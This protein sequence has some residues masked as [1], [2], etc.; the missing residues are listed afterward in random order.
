MK[1]EGLA[2]EDGLMMR[3]MLDFPSGLELHIGVRDSAWCARPARWLVGSSTRPLGLPTRWSRWLV[4]LDQSCLSDPASP[5]MYMACHSRLSMAMGARV[6]HTRLWAAPATAG[7]FG[8]DRLLCCP[9]CS[10]S[11]LGQTRAKLAV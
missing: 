9:A 6:T 11:L 2:L 8:M 10:S 7:T 5:V 1:N 3:S 4:H